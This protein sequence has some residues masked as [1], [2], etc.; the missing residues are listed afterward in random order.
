MRAVMRKDYKRALKSIVRKS[1]LRP[2]DL[3]AIGTAYHDDLENRLFED[4]ELRRFLGLMMDQSI[5]MTTPYGPEP[6]FAS[7]AKDRLKGKGLFEGYFLPVRLTCLFFTKDDIIIGDAVFDSRSGDFQSRI[8]R[9]PRKGLKGLSTHIA[10]TSEAVPTQRLLNWLS[11]HRFTAR[12]EKKIGEVLQKYDRKFRLAQKRGRTLPEPPYRLQR[13]TRY[14]KLERR[15]AKPLYLPM[16][17][18]HHLARTSKAKSGPARDLTPIHAGDAII[19]RPVTQKPVS[20]SASHLEYRTGWSLMADLTIAALLC[21]ASV[22]LTGLISVDHS[23]AITS[24]QMNGVMIERNGRDAPLLADHQTLPAD[25]KEKAWHNENWGFSCARVLTVMKET[26]NWRSETLA[27]V[28]KGHAVILRKGQR[29]S[30]APLPPGWVEIQMMENGQ[31]IS[32]FG[33]GEYFE[34]QNAAGPMVCR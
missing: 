16:S 1:G 6:D 26:P 21:T 23:K 12:E 4:D 5:R 18:R 10:N 3:Q 17:M 31:I 2:S 33:A 20:A 15:D 34:T 27:S 9:T 29:E 28:K 7:K 8:T 14:L 22:L 13:E 30:G 25:L 32:G 11:E 24:T 19:H